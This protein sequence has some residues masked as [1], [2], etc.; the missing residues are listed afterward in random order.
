[1]PD[2][3]VPLTVVGGYLGAGKT[4]I[5]NALLRR[6]GGRRLGVVVNDFGSLPVDVALLD[7]PA[8]GG[9]VNLPN[10]CVCCTLG[11]DLHDALAAMLAARPRPD[12]VVIEASGVANPAVAAAW[13]TAPP[14]EPGGVLVVA[15][16]DAIRSVARDRYVG[17][18][19]VRQL[20]GAD[21]ILVTRSDLCAPAARDAVDD[22]LEERAPGVPRITAT[23]GDVPTDVILG[24]RPAGVRPAGHQHDVGALY[25]VT[26]WAA[27]APVGRAGLDRFLAALAPG[28]LRAKGVI[29]LDDG[30]GVVVQV[31]GARVEVRGSEPPARSALTV[32]ARRGTPAAPF[33]LLA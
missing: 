12:H 10:G 20:A 18:E 19:V 26:E 25:S 9:V 11:A 5:L 6:P 23:N 16:A 29:A 30:T 24:A 1:M 8:T 17:G 32:I 7:A 33:E 22:W 28:V 21:I 14:F 15:A 27:D 13:G 31:V 2:P 3:A 4:T